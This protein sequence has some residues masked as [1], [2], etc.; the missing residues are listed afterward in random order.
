MF[1][2]LSY[3]KEADSNMYAINVIIDHKKT[4]KK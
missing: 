3:I 4:K 1:A 2:T